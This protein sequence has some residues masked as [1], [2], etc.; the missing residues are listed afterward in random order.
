MTPSKP[1]KPGLGLT[2]EALPPMG[3]SSSSPLSPTTGMDASIGEDAIT[4]IVETRSTR[5]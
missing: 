3:E 2:Q 5:F 1:S 4:E